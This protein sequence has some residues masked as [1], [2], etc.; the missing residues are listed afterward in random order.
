MLAA[1]GLSVYSTGRDTHMFIEWVPV[2]NNLTKRVYREMS[3]EVI[4]KTCAFTHAQVS[5]QFKFIVSIQIASM[6]HLQLSIK[7]NTG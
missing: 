1:L 3:I 7:I 5:T 2:V 4:Q 6:T